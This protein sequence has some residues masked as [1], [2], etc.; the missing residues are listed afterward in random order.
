MWNAF[1]EG[2]TT[3]I[4]CKKGTGCDPEF[5]RGETG[6][7]TY[8]PLG[9]ATFPWIPAIGRWICPARPRPS[10]SPALAVDSASERVSNGAD[11]AP[12]FAPVGSDSKAPEV[13]VPFVR[14]QGGTYA[15]YSTGSR[16]NTPLGGDHRA[17]PRSTRH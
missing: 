15:Q 2:Q 11:F 7:R 5:T 12:Q 1:H 16:G 10:T 14:R 4:A 8:S 3:L 9:A 17:R 6:S 13:V